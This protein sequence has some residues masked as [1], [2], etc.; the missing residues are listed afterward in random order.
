MFDLGDPGD[1][2]AHAVG[3]LVQGETAAF[4]HVRQAPAASL[5]EHGADRGVKDVLAGWVVSHF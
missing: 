4:T 5:V 1:G 2:D 3:D